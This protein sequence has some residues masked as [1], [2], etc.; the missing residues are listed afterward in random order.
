MN[1]LIFLKTI[2]RLQQLLL[3]TFIFGIN[4]SIPLD[5]PRK[6]VLPSHARLFSLKLDIPVKNQNSNEL[7]SFDGMNDIVNALKNWRKYKDSISFEDLTQNWIKNNASTPEMKCEANFYKGYSFAFQFLSN[8]TYVN[9]SQAESRL[10]LMKL[11]NGRL[12]IG[13]S[14]FLAAAGKNENVKNLETYEMTATDSIEMS[15]YPTINENINVNN[16]FEKLDDNIFKVDSF[17]LN[18]N[19][20]VNLSIDNKLN[21]NMQSNSIK[22]IDSSIDNDLNLF[23]SDNTVHIGYTT[24]ENV[25]D[26]YTSDVQKNIVNTLQHNKSEENTFNLNT[27]NKSKN[28]TSN[29]NNSESNT[30]YEN[31]SEK[32]N[33]FVNNTKEIKSYVNSLNVNHEN[34][35]QPKVNPLEIMKKIVKGKFYIKIINF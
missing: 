20:N 22:T 29:E 18:N 30:S 21:N 2:L 17:N 8:L 9:L 19:N 31:K 4:L 7:V 24:D 33:S 12:N 35:N 23:K 28:N 10:Q 3:L 25:V 26:V 11:V 1:G 5:P 14:T 15:L 6:M 34:M 13:K 16:N 32:N 27:S